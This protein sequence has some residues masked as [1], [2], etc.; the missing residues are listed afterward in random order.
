VSQAGW[1]DRAAEM[2]RR[3]APGTDYRDAAQARGLGLDARGA[4]LGAL[5]MYRDAAMGAAPSAAQ[6]TLQRGADAAAAQARSLA[7]S[8][9]GTGVQRAAAGLAGI[10]AASRATQDAAAGAA[11]LR[12]QEI[13][14]ARAGLA[15]LASTM[16]QGDL[17][18]QGQD[19]GQAQFLTDAALRQRAMNDALTGQAWG[20]GSRASEAD[21][22]GRMRYQEGSAANDLATQ[23]LNLGIATGNAA[24]DER[25]MNAILGGA[26]GGAQAGLG[27]Y[28]PPTGGVR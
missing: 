6:A 2:Q 24:A 11:A 20:L 3:A 7:A 9:R 1:D 22:H 5:D 19:A 21:Q 26:L 27:F 15:G 23:R 16:R 25:N 14:A 13:A 28:R 4:Q 17:A 18:L 10:S 12:A 8:A